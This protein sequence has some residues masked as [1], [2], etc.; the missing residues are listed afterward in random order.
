MDDQ[1]HST[2]IQLSLKSSK[3]DPFRRGVHIVIG[4]TQDD[5][6]PVAALLAY[7]A[8]RGGGGGGG[9]CV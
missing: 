3:T 5:L 6:C 2:T 7:L 8:V 9:G 1:E 4:S